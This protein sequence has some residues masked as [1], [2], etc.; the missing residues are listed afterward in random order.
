VYVI[1][2]TC[3]KMFSEMQSLQGV[4]DYLFLMR[5]ALAVPVVAGKRILAAHYLRNRAAS[6]AAHLSGLGA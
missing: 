3:L 5:S 2:L 4:E 1:D 6:N